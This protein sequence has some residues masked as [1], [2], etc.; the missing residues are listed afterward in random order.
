VADARLDWMTR[1][2]RDP[3]LLE[4]YEVEVLPM[5]SIG[6]V[7]ELLRATMPLPQ[8]SIEEAGALVIE[9]LVNRTRSRKSRLRKLRES[10]P[11]T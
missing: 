3:A 10:V 1:F 5:L 4:Q 8:L 2:K 11:G 9:H 7:R 6:H